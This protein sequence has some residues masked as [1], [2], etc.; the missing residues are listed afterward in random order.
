VI[1]VSSKNKKKGYF[2]RKNIGK[3]NKNS[4]LPSMTEK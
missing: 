1:S 2:G 4:E 3:L